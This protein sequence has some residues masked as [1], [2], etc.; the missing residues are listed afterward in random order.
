DCGDEIAEKRLMF[1]PH[2]LTCISC[3][4][5]REMEENNRKKMR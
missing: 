5:A 3:A 2:F 4:E 1:N